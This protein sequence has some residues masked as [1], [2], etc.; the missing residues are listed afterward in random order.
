MTDIRDL[1]IDFD[2]EDNNEKTAENG[3][4]SSVDGHVKIAEQL[5][6]LS[7]EDTI[8]DDLLKVAIFQELAPDIE[9]NISEV[10]NVS[11]KGTDEAS[12]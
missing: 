4:I 9:K 11:N 10:D 1:I 2:G 8:V 12:S 6:A 5:E 7:E 3:N